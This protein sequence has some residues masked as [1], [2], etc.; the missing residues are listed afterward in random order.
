MSD[1][2][3]PKPTVAS[4]H[5]L[6]QLAHEAAKTA[7]GV[8]ESQ[9]GQLTKVAG[10]QVALAKAFSLVRDRVEKLATSMDATVVNSKLDGMMARLEAIEKRASGETGDW[11]PVIQAL[12][13]RLREVAEKVGH[14]ESGQRGLA[15]V[16]GEGSL[17][18]EL[19]AVREQ[20]AVNRDAIAAAD[21]GPVVA[22]LASR[23]DYLKLQDEAVTGTFLKIGN[24]LEELERKVR[25]LG[26][27]VVVDLAAAEVYGDVV[28]PVGNT[29]SMKVL[30]VMRLVDA[31]EKDGEFVSNQ[32]RFKFRGVD[33]AM[34]AVGRAMRSVGLTLQ[35]KVLDRQMTQDSVVKRDG[36]GHEYT[37]LWT[38]TVLT[39]A[40]EFV[41]PATGHKHT[42]EMVGEGRDVSDKSSSKAA[43]MACKYSL[44]Q[45][46]M[47][48]VEG[49]NDTDSDN[50]RPVVEQP[51]QSRDFQHP[52]PPSSGG[53]PVPNNPGSTE[54]QT[55]P[56]PYAPA[57]KAVALV[58]WVQ[59]VQ[60]LPAAEALGKLKTAKQRAEQ[61]D[62]NDYVVEGVTVDL[63]ISTALRSVN[64]AVN[65]IAG[66][67][68]ITREGQQAGE[69][70]RA[71][72]A[73]THAQ[74]EQALKTIDSDV[75]QDMVNLAVATVN[76]YIAA[77]PEE[78]AALIAKTPESWRSDPVEVQEPPVD[79]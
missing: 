76:A 31:I 61:H 29:A 58:R 72:A 25:Q 47:I 59:E 73:P 19:I 21:V 75:P 24:R 77:H 55:A 39:M 45:G 54:P 60:S 44:F 2:V 5:E 65:R 50:E 64:A 37:Q 40:Y 57:E 28:K 53:T 4:V 67:Q 56:P 78:R 79:Y 36:K 51:Q 3:T 42:L 68:G 74:Y 7:L 1:T 12:D 8:S 48:P 62:L 18:D 70:A 16:V 34:D 71:A 6:A 13:V 20:M 11:G 49:F 9:A 66:G 41:D 52:R 30:E 10:E 23:V 33:Q 63:H 26:E 46:L 15:E 69:G 43:A 27:S 17:I 35:T 32:A 38:T 22:D 14:L